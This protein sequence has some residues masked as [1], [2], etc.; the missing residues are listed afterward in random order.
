MSQEKIHATGRRKNATASLWL[1]PGNG[2]WIVNG[3][4]LVGYL[5][6]ESLGSHASEPMKITNMSGRFDVIVAASGGGLSGQAG[7]IRHALAR[8]LSAFNPDLRKP[9]KLAGML[10]RDP[11]MVERKKYGQPK[12]RKRFQFSKR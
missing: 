2:K 9:L 11:R 7:A 3:K 6:R 1:A 4:D 8:A 5:T 10:T 12:A